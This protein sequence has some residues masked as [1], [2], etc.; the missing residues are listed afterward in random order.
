MCRRGPAKVKAC[1]SILFTE[2]YPGPEVKIKSE[3]L[4]K[5]GN[6]TLNQSF[7]ANKKNVF[8]LNFAANLLF[9]FKFFQFVCIKTAEN[10]Y[11]NQRST[12]TLVEINNKSHFKEKN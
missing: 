8:L 5:V 11:F 4:F 2:G 3:H 1:K 9:F 7:G 12:L 6:K 10:D